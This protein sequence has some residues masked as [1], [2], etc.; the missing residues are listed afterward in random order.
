MYEKYAVNGTDDDNEG[1]IDSE[2]DIE[3]PLSHCYS[4]DN[5][6]ARG[7]VTVS[8]EPSGARMVSSSHGDLRIWDFGG[9]SASNPRPFFE[10][11]P[12][13]GQPIHT[14]FEQGL[15]IAYG[16]APTAKVHNRQGD[17]LTETARGDMY[18][19][20]LRN[21]KGHISEITAVSVYDSAHFFTGSRDNT[22][23]K[24]AVENAKRGQEALYVCGSRQSQ[25]HVTS[26]ACDE[27][28]V[29]GQNSGQILLFDK[30]ERPELKLVEDSAVKAMHLIDGQLTCLTKSR[31]SVWDL[32]N[33]K[34]PIMTTRVI[35]R[36]MA[37]GPDGQ[38]AVVR[39]DEIEIL[40]KSDLQRVAGT[41]AKEATCVAW[42]GTINQIVY[43]CRDGSVKIAFDPKVST[44]GIL[45]ALGKG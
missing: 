4:I 33:A 16:S 34:K 1:S 24:W 12:F 15:L 19:Y 35:A 27:K 2:F 36:D 39:E 14:Q 5:A 25:D 20:D 3:V 45:I 37:Q 38:L 31:I 23:R 32:R 43:G 17:L 18:L 13:E 30:T 28:V 26:L 42:N 10:T 41:P 9:F 11:I 21:T 29:C 44:K 7:V 40:D 6:H 22:V 8:V